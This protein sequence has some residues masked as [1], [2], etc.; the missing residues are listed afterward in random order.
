MHGK[1]PYDR[2][3]PRIKDFVV[4]LFGLILI[5]YEATRLQP[6]RDTLIVGLVLLIAPQARARVI[7]RFLGGSNDDRQ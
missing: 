1:D 5:A 7:D 4:S 3:A 2:W 6:N